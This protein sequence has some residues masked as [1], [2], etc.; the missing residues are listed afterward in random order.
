MQRFFAED[1]PAKIWFVVVPVLIWIFGLLKFQPQFVLM[2]DLRYMLSFILLA[3]FGIPISFLISGIAGS[4][5]ISSLY[6][7]RAIM[8]GGPFYV[9]DTVQILS[10]EHE[11][12]VV[13]I[14]AEYMES[15]FWVDLGED[16]VAKNANC[17][18][19]AQL[20]RV[21]AEELTIGSKPDS[22]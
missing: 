11:G 9:D 15:L 1:K 2:S 14:T 5:V 8:N 19:Q 6:R 21:S 22:G 12:K 4:I 16:A 3:L 18:N 20:A 13:R 7:E 17:F 10:G